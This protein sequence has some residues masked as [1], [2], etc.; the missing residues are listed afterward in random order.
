MNK[1]RTKK[2]KKMNLKRMIHSSPKSFEID[3]LKGE[4]ICQKK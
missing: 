3:K 4:L 1:I 2:L